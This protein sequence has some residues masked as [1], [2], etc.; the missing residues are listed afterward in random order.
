MPI[1]NIP[2]N[3]QGNTG[4]LVCCPMGQSAAFSRDSPDA[5]FGNF[6]V[7]WNRPSRL[8]RGARHVTAAVLDSS[9]RVSNFGIVAD[10][11][12]DLSDVNGQL[13]ILG[14]D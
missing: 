9:F 6:A 13:F 12:G 14:I 1:G 8:R 5:A 3:R 4:I 2:E 10:F 7:S 11:C